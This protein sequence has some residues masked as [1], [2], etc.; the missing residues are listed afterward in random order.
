MSTEALF[1]IYIRLYIYYLFIS[2]RSEKLMEMLSCSF[3]EQ[4]DD[5]NKTNAAEVLNLE[6]Y[7]LE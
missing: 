6:L 1:V 7:N 2:A 5:T 4:M 3:A